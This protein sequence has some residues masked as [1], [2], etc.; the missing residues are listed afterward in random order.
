MISKHATEQEIIDEMSQQQLRTLRGHGVEKILD[1]ETTVDEVLR[2][3][4]VGH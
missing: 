4:M 2:T 1:G 3:T